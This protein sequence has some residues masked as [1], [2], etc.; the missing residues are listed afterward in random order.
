MND[1]T[2]EKRDELLGRLTVI[3]TRLGQI[4]DGPARDE[5]KAEVRQLTRLLWLDG[6]P[7]P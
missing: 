5:L 6:K 3:S 2:Q 4:P 1:L 7:E